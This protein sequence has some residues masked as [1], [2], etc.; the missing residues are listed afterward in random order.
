M[1]LAGILSPKAWIS[2]FL[3]T[4]FL[5]F[6]ASA[7]IAHKKVAVEQTSFSMEFPFE[8]P[9]PLSEA[10][11]KALTTDRGIADVMKDDQLSIES[12]PKDWFT[13]SEV[14]LGPNS[15]TDLV[16]MGIGISMGP[17]SAGF[18]ILRQ[19]PQGYEIV[20]AVHAHSL[21]LLDSS[22]NG[23]RDIES[24][25]STLNESNSDIYK[26]DGHRYQIGEPIQESPSSKVPAGEAKFTPEQLEQY[27]LVYKNSDVQYLRTLFDT[28]LKNS[29]GTEEE[30]QQ[31][32]KWNKDYFRSKFMVMSRENNMFGGTLI[33]ILFQDRPDKVFVAWI[34]PDGSNKELTLR[35]L[36]VG[37]FT[38][39]DLKRIRIR[40]KKLIE[41]KVHAM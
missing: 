3:L 29:G 1:N 25:L 16:V 33:T 18:W 6:P 11:K 34:Y 31:L 24:G 40:Y 19:T 22:T 21:A 36:D 13:A 26:F 28:Y 2:T 20:L 23:F 14:H 35:R 4:G 8:Q 41:D 12:I 15:E 7:Q 38:D 27:S 9:V 39:E 32:Q 5:L 30:R 37:D 17:Y 10:A